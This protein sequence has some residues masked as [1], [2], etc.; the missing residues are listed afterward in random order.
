[1]TTKTNQLH[2]R[3]LESAR[4][5]TQFGEF[6]LAIFSNSTD[7]KEHL[8]L[9]MGDISKKDDILVRVHSECYTGDV[10]GSKRCDCGQQL[11]RAMKMISEVG[12]GVILYLRQEGR[13]IGLL[14]KL[15]AYNLQ[16]QG[17]DTVE[18]NLLLGHQV[19]E[20]DYTI[21]VRILEALEI[22]SIQLLTNNPQK[23]DSLQKMGIRVTNRIPLHGEINSENAKY[24]QTKIDRLNHFPVQPGNIETSQWP[25]MKHV[26]NRLATAELFCQQ[27]ER[28][29]VTLSYAQTLDGSIALEAGQRLEI[30][31]PLTYAFTHQLRANHEAILVGI[32]TVLADNP[33]LNVRLVTGANPQPIILDS[34][35]RCPLDA[36]LLQNETLPWVI[37]SEQADETR[38]AELEALGARV[39][40]TSANQARRID[41]NELL[42]FLAKHGIQRLMVEGGQ[43][44]ITSFIQAGL[45]DQVVLTIAP[46]FVGGLP[47]I[48]KLA[49]IPRLENLHHQSLA[50]DIIIRGDVSWE[51]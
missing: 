14:E 23:M 38:Q 3:K 35:L 6:Q 44:I 40:R 34:Q 10:L 37:T 49:E 5:P 24:I 39:F 46:M 31:N 30:S 45:I 4:L 27:H 17:Y 33:Q 50:D 19:D 22:R 8:A 29:F 15:R 48:G 36:K 9:L 18:A 41:L 11:Q 43:Q 20:R 1:M 47:A 25:I 42:R 21:A 32:G 12:L 13:G 2:V 26:D 7:N 28:P 16:D 51:K